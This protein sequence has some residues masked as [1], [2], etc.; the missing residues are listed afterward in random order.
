M[1]V[2]SLPLTPG[3]NAGIV[4]E[5]RNAKPTVVDPSV[6][7]PKTFFEIPL[8][9]FILVFLA[10]FAIMEIVGL[11]QSIPY[12]VRGFN[13]FWWY[14]AF[15]LLGLALNVFGFYSV[16]RLI[17]EYMIVYTWALIMLLI[18]NV[19]RFITWMVFGYFIGATITLILQAIII[20]ICAVDDGFKPHNIPVRQATKRSTGP[21]AGELRNAKPTIANPSVPEPKTFCEIPLRALMLVYLALFAIMEIVGLAQ[22]IPFAGRGFNVFWFYIA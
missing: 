2:K 10:L 4:F 21:T 22:S 7:V 11:A 15:D 12:A 20:D 18:V 16:H 17:P 19:I 1:P 6:P 13:I 8:R 9:A 5:L 14:I 3:M